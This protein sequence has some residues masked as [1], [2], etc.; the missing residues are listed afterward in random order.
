M[1]FNTL[2]RFVDALKKLYNSWTMLK[3]LRVSK[4][5]FAASLTTKLRV[6]AEQGT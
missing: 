5:I 3:K 6:W 1:L 4:E 2:H